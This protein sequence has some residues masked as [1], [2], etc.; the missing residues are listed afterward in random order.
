LHPH[1]TFYLYDIP[2]QLYVCE[3][4]LKSVFPGQVVSYQETKDLK[5]L[6]PQGDGRIYI[7]GNWRFEMIRDVSVDLFWNCASF[8][9]MEPEVVS[10]YLSFLS[11]Q[12]QNVFLLEAMKG[13]HVAKHQGDAGVLKRT[14]LED[15]QKGL[16]GFEMVDLSPLFVIPRVFSDK[17]YS[18]LFWKKITKILSKSR[19]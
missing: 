14:T 4:Y 17:D 8:Q 5:T 1:L 3:Q 18:I 16:K 2:P 13:Q 11:G 9:E 15:Y 19:V 7:F 6:P 10:N 12:V